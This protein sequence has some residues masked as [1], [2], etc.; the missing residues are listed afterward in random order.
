M[1]YCVSIM[2]QWK[3]CFNL[4]GN[5]ESENVEGGEG[6]AEG[7]V[8]LGV[9]ARLRAPERQEAITSPSDPHK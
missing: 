2:S 7:P 9:Q 8:S 5:K 1:A 3:R 6:G 4:N